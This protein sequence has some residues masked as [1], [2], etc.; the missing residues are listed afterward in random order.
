MVF[1]GDIAFYMATLVF[2]AGVFMV[3]QAKQGASTGSHFLRRSGYLVIVLSILGAS[4]TV[5]YWMKYYTQGVYDRPH[6]FKHS[7]MM[8][9]ANNKLHSCMGG[10]HGQTMDSSMIEQ[11][12][13]CLSGK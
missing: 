9:H 2:A 12:R 7:M 3:H 11:M 13:S 5:Y 10:M 8:N 6:S 1:L 4:C